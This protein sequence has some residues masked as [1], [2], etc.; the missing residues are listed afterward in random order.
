M[1]K[2][3]PI[4]VLHG[5]PGLDQTYLLPQIS[6]LAKNHQ[7]IFYDQRGSGQ[8]VSDMLDPSLMTLNKREVVNE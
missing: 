7:V 2:G 4:I 6:R 5:G 8:S 3:D 1:G